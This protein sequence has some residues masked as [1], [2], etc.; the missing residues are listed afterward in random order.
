MKVSQSTGGL[1]MTR[2]IAEL[3]ENQS[4]AAVWIKEKY[5]AGPSVFDPKKHIF[6]ASPTAEFIGAPREV[7][8][9]WIAQSTKHDHI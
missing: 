1:P 6:D 9:A 4:I 5:K 8:E 3:D 7:I 2:F